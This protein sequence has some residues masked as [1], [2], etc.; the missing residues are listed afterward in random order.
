MAFLVGVEVDAWHRSCDER[1]ECPCSI[2][3][4]DVRDGRGGGC[5]GDGEDVG[6]VEAEGGAE[7]DVA[8]RVS[9]GGGEGSH[10]R[11]G[12]VDVLEAKAIDDGN[13]KQNYKKEEDK[14]QAS[15][16]EPILPFW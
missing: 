15:A 2:G 8:L 4:V 1:I 10:A 6:V 5:R 12:E 13:G 3:P 7:G 11:H 16:Q 9:Q 14:P